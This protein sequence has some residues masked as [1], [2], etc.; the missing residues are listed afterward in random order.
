MV[1]HRV[2]SDDEVMSRFVADRI[3]ACLDEKPDSLICLATGATPTRTYELLSERHLRHPS[4]LAKARLLKLDEWG[5]LAMDDPAS[6]EA[7]LRRVLVD[8]HGL[9][10]RYVAFQSCPPDADLECQRIS[11]WLEQNGPIDLCV[12][13]LGINGHLGF[14][15][16]AP[17]LQPHS[18][19][20]RLS[21]ASLGHRMVAE[22]RSRPT[23]GLTLGMADLLCSREIF[24]LVS[25]PVKREPLQQLLSG[26]IT[27]QFPASLLHL[28]AN[29]MIICDSSAVS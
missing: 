15:E 16:P 13:G 29:T 24:L 14:N 25:G 2:F 17:F 7:Y 26:Q 3:A 22:A 11:S 19:V 20:A 5:G 12:L 9:A 28:H 27:T 6:C 21:E 23:F 4:L 18:H 1:K 10:D 8:R